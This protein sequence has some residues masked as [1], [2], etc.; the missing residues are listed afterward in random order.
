MIRGNLLWELICDAARC[1]S[2]GLQ[3]KKI[4]TF[5]KNF[6]SVVE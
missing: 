5:L 2:N 3:K 6:D 1:R 4:D